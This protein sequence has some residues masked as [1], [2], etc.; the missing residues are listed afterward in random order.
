MLRARSPWVAAALLF[1]AGP[2]LA[3]DEPGNAPIGI[4]RA[5]DGGLEPAK[6]DPAKARLAAVLA[7]ITDPKV[8][9]RI[10][11]AL[12]RGGPIVSDVTG[13]TV[14]DA[15]PMEG[16]T[17]FRL[18]VRDRYSVEIIDALADYKAR[19]PDGKLADLVAPGVPSDPAKE[20]IDAVL[21]DIY[22][23][24]LRTRIEDALRRGGP[25]VS[26]VTGKS[27]SDA[28]PMPGT[29]PFRL[30]VPDSYATEILEALKDY[31][32]RHP[33]G[34]LGDLVAPGV[35][36]DPA[37]ERIDAVLANVYEP[38][39][40]AGLEEALRKGTPIT[41][42]VTDK[43]MSD[44][45]PL[46]GARTHHLVLPD[47]YAKEVLAALEDF[48]ARNPGKPF[49][50]LLASP[51]ATPTPGAGREVTRGVV[52]NAPAAA[53]RDLVARSTSHLKLR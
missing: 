38:G 28:R 23:A 8:R 42:Y 27:V 12:R 20:R 1:A 49:A 13:K 37:K 47:S 33:E 9:T 45:L 35:P 46:P 25:I 53:L 16:S 18:P 10:E 11:D 32:A 21:G 22:D 24:K 48:K 7:N 3:Q 36:S 51:G 30:P 29:T 52:A 41:A 15:K 19:N 4:R 5:L 2:V 43:V 39:I 14:A 17:R 6:A 40:R 31:K 26:D 50:D 44:G 34:R